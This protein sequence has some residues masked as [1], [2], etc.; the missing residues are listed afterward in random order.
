MLELGFEPLSTA[1][2]CLPAR[3]PQIF[4]LFDGEEMPYSRTDNMNDL[5]RRLNA[6]I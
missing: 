3:L 1:S 2:K 5:P 4:R 6:F